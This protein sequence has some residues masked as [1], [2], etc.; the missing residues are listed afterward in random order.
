MGGLDSTWS[1]RSVDLGLVLLS[2]LVGNGFVRVKSRVSTI[3]VFGI[4]EIV[5]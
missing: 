1:L 5:M 4:I 2:Y 3:S